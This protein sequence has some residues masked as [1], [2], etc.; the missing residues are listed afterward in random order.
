MIEGVG[1]I[2]E[3]QHGAKTEEE[4]TSAGLRKVPLTA[5][6]IA[7]LE[8]Q[9]LAH[10]A[11]EVILVQ[12]GLQLLDWCVTGQF[13]F[14]LARWNCCPLPVVWHQSSRWWEHAQR[15]HVV[16]GHCRFD[17]PHLVEVHF[18]TFWLLASPASAAPPTLELRPH[19]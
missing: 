10:F 14:F 1:C 16:P 9:N 5:Q 17:H 6:S 19:R 13:S 18:R 12:G 15:L 11:A 7:D 4:C 3:A 2:I 8:Q